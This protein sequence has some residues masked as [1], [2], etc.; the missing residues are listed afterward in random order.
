MVFPVASQVNVNGCRDGCGR[1]SSRS[2]SSESN[3]L[4][5]N[6]GTCFGAGRYQNITGAVTKLE[7]E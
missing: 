3:G 7:N 4:R 2:D 6:V 5:R 1:N